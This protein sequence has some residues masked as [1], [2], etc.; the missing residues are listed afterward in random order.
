M[1]AQSNTD[2]DKVLDLAFIDEDK[3][4]GEKLFEL[5]SKSESLVT[6]VLALDSSLTST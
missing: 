3:L 1:R 4:N 2:G 6:I 5:L